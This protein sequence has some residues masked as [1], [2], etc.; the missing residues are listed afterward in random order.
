M[1]LLNDLG[2]AGAPERA[3]VSGRA[4]GTTWT[5]DQI[6]PDP[7]SGNYFSE[8]NADNI[9]N[10][11]MIYS[12]NPTGPVF[13][14][15]PDGPNKKLIFQAYMDNGGAWA[16]QHSASDFENGGKWSWF[17]DNVAGGWFVDHNGETTPGTIAWQAGFADHP[18]LKGL[19]T[20]WNTQD[21]WYVMN[22]DIEAVPG[23]KILAKVTTV[24]TNNYPNATLRPAVWIKE[25]AKGGRAFY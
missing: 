11:K 21:E 2:M 1:Q 14:N 20:P 12:D 25:N 6:K 3:T 4:N 22:R 9:K 15:A 18:I 16:G 13:T 8:V 19:A 10:Y 5:V 17:Q 7:A 24:G 23:F